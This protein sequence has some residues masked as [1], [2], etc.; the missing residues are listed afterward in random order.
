MGEADR[1]GVLGSVGE[2]VRAGVA[3]NSENVGDSV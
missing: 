1:T 3:P 2:A